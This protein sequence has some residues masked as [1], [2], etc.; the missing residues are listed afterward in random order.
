MKHLAIAGLALSLGACATL[1]TG[2]LG[3]S[4]TIIA[5]QNA[6]VAA[7]SFLPTAGT[8]ANIIKANDPKL[9]TAEAVA[10]AI[11]AAIAP[12]TQHA[13]I[14]TTPKVDGVAIVGAFVSAR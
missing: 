6:A 12:T 4:D 9:I 1:G 2:G 13:L 3:S 10:A 5:I 8:I 11:C 7:C 14:A